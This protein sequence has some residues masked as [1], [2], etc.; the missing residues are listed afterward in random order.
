[1]MEVDLIVVELMIYEFDWMAELDLVAELDLMM[2]VSLELFPFLKSL[3]LKAK[4]IYQ[5]ILDKNI[6]RDLLSCASSIFLNQFWARAVPARPFK[7]FADTVPNEVADADQTASFGLADSK[8][9]CPLK[10]FVNEARCVK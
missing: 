6:N 9:Y 7:K 1:M 4:H 2:E 5:D 10:S 8:M 3:S